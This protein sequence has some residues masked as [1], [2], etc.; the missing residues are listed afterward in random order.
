MV[1]LEMTKAKTQK[2]AVEEEATSLRRE[3]QLQQREL[4]EVKQAA[5]ESRSQ[6]LELQ[7]TGENSKSQIQ[8]RVVWEDR[9][10]FGRIVLHP[11]RSA[12]SRPIK[13]P[14]YGNMFTFV[15]HSSSFAISIVSNCSSSR[16]RKRQR[17]QQWKASSKKWRHRRRRRSEPCSLNAP[18]EWAQWNEQ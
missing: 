10:V 16:R 3:M 8:V 12:Q 9:F 18:N 4:E 5:A 6:L 2:D 14:P 1:S 17:M 7:A 11:A 15:V 13:L